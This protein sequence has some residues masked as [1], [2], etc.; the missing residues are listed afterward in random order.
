MVEQSSNTRPAYFWPLLALIAGIVVG[1]IIGW[2]IWPVSYKNTLPQDLRSAERDQYLAMVAESYAAN[3][4]LPLAQERTQTW[5]RED[6]AKALANLQARLESTDARQAANVEALGAGLNLRSAVTQPTSGAAPA[7]SARFPWKAVFTSLLWV[8]LALIG[9]VGLAW[10]FMKWRAARNRPVTPAITSVP[11]PAPAPSVSIPAPAQPMAGTTPRSAEEIARQAKST[12]PLP[13]AA[14]DLW[15]T[16]SEAEPAFGADASEKT[17]I[18]SAPSAAREVWTAAPVSAAPAVSPTPAPVRPAAPPAE[19]QRRPA[20]PAPAAGPTFTK[21]GDYVA[22]YQMGEPDY[23][24]AFD[25]NDA[26]DG[27]MGQCAL[28]LSDPTGRNRDQADSLQAWLWDSS[29]PDTKTIVLMS[30]G[31]YRDTARRSEVAGANPVIQVRPGAEFE[32]ESHDLLLRG[33]VEKADYTDQDPPR[34][35][36]AEL[37]LRMQ[38]YRKG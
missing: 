4:N 12:W 7:K 33:R 6:L 5:S 26:V 21:I 29:D 15:T 34:G 25:I 35:I 2:G 24:E 38:V 16:E 9:I 27:Y 13:A 32:L 37:Q 8:L 11:A 23:D 17:S 31:K 28:Q 19:P 36:F 1:L 18:P 30:E 20:V 14:P 22:I 3:N 10:L